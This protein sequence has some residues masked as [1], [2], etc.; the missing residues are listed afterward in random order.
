MPPGDSRV[1][2]GSKRGPSPTK[3]GAVQ[4]LNDGGDGGDGGGV[5]GRHTRHTLDLIVDVSSP[6]RRCQPDLTRWLSLR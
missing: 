1:G 6:A 2:G 4:E 3:G 5:T